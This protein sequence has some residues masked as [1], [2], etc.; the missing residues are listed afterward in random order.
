MRGFQLNKSTPGGKTSSGTLQDCVHNQWL[1]PFGETGFNVTPR[2]RATHTGAQRSNCFGG[3]HNGK[4]TK[5]PTNRNTF[6][7]ERACRLRFRR[8]LLVPGRAAAATARIR[9]RRLRT[10]AWLCMGRRI[11]EP[12]RRTVGLGQRAL[13]AAAPRAK[14]VGARSMGA[15]R[16]RLALPPRTL[17]IAVRAC[18]CVCL[19]VTPRS[20]TWS[21][22]P[23][24][25]RDTLARSRSRCCG[26]CCRRVP[27]RPAVRRS[28]YRVPRCCTAR[29]ESI[30]AA[31]RT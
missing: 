30:H 20:R 13:G 28:R 19:R 9:R 10:R 6:G 23:P 14:G 24:R 17:A 16:T 15:W 4:T 26:S 8:I 22:P 21:C 11:L 12:A 1:H 29:G 25:A 2:P 18:A 5:R 31:G 3:R 27:C 7:R